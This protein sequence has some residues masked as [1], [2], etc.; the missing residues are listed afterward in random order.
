MKK[1]VAIDEAGHVYRFPSD[2]KQ[3]VTFVRDELFGQPGSHP[4]IRCQDLIRVLIDRVNFLNEQDPSH[5]NIEIL[6]SLRHALT[7]FETRALRRKLEK[8]PYPERIVTDEAGHVFGLNEDD[9]G[10]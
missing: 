4:G 7:C 3:R 10:A 9:D 8:V 1:R 5:E 6:R 2:P